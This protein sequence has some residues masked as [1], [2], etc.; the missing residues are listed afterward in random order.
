MACRNAFFLLERDQNL[1]SDEK[2]KIKTIYM[3]ID[4]R[5]RSDLSSCRMTAGIWSNCETEMAQLV[6]IECIQCL[7][8][9]DVG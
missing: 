2:Q 3:T 1:I 5:L 8:V 9:T 7:L 6:V 4:G